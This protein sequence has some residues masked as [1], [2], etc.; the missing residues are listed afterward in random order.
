MRL[1]NAETRLKELKSALA[2]LG[3]EATAAM[4]SV[5]EQ[6][7]QMTLQSLRTMVFLNSL[8]QYSLGNV[9]TDWTLMCLTGG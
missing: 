9:T 3:K 8:W 2:A 4:L 7:Q 1:Q 5:E 6:Q